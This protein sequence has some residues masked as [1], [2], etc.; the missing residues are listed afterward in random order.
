MTTTITA[1][2]ITIDGPRAWMVVEHSKCPNHD[3]CGCERFGLPIGLPHCKL[4]CELA[5]PSDLARLLYNENVI[6]EIAVPQSKKPKCDHRVIEKDTQWEDHQRTCPS[7]LRVHVVRVMPIVDYRSTET[8]F[9]RLK[10]GPKGVDY[11]ATLMRANPR[12]DPLS[13]I[14]L[15]AD[16]A[17]NKY[18]VELAV[19]S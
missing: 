10:L 9:D 7:I 13:L 15:P 1:S 3:P 6:F 5:E 2:S 16:A 11:P 18:A 19:H 17:P 4:S 14:N 12:Y 8:G